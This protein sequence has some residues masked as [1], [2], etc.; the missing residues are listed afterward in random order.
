[1]RGIRICSRVR[2]TRVCTEARS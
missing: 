1:M 2:N